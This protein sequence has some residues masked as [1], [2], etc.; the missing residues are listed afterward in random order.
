MARP[1]V[2]KPCSREGCPNKAD[3]R[4]MCHNHYEV[5]RRKFVGTLTPHGVAEGLV[6]KAL[7][8]TRAQ[9]AEKTGLSDAG[10]VVALRK[11]RDDE[12]A[13]IERFIPPE[14]YRGGKWKPFYARGAGPD[15]VLDPAVV[16]E[17]ALAMRRRQES[18]ARQAKRELRATIQIASVYADVFNLTGRKP[19]PEVTD[20]REE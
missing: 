1:F 9:L 17:Y 4:G 7:P 14:G 13:F 20:Y 18:Q 15:A 6:L 19:C 3:A 16:R 5:W 2:P 8:G 12:K 10:V 11:L